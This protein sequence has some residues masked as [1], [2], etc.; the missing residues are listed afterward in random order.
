MRGGTEKWHQ[1]ESPEIPDK[2]ET[3]EIPCLP[4]GGKKTS[5]ERTKHQREQDNIRENKIDR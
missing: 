3:S 1:T 5:S 4:L 2:G